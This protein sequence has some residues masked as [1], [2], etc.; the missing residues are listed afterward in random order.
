MIAGCEEALHSAAAAVT[1][2]AWTVGWCIFSNSPAVRIK[3]GGQTRGS[4]SAMPQK[5]PPRLAHSKS[6]CNGERTLSNG[7]AAL[8][9]T[10]QKGG[11]ADKA[12]NR[13][14]CTQLHA[15]QSWDMNRA[16]SAQRHRAA[17]P[18][19]EAPVWCAMSAWLWGGNLTTCGWHNR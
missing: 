14:S 17:E 4:S 2:G 9:Q 13:P 18:R 8:V 1:A 19:A 12:P 7:H 11:Q 3:W 10:F 5:P 6:A 16:S 15:H